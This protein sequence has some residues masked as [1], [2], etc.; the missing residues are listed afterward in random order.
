MSDFH[1]AQGI[2]DMDKEHLREIDGVVF[3]LD[4]YARHCMHDTP[5]PVAEVSAS[6]QDTATDTQV[7]SPT[8]VFPCDPVHVGWHESTPESRYPIMAGA[9]AP[10][11]CESVTQQVLHMPT[12]SAGS[13]TS[14]F[15][16]SFATSYATSYQGSFVGSY[17]TGSGSWATSMHGMSNMSVCPVAGYG[18]ELI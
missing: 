17:H 16:S 18:L 10:S 2:L 7:T 9:T 6:P 13:W 12:G 3:D 5:A 8:P 14:S 1:P 4:S 15:A 11:T